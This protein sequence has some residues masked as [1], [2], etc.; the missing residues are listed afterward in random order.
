MIVEPETSPPTATE[1]SPEAVTTFAACASCQ[2][3]VRSAASSWSSSSS[4]RSWMRSAPSASSSSGCAAT[5]ST[6]SCAAGFCSTP[7]LSRSQ[8]FSA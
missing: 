2:I 4:L 1:R 7:G 3:F 5:S 8:S 6:A